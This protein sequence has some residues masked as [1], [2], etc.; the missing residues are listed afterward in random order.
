MSILKGKYSFPLRANISVKKLWGFD[1]ETYGNKNTFYMGSIVGDDGIQQIFYSKDDFI[2]YLFKNYKLFT[3]GYICATNLGF[4]ITA[5]FDNH[6]KLKDIHPIIKNSNMIFCSFDTI[7][8]RHKLKF[9]DT[10]NFCP[11]SVETWGRILNF[12]K[13][14][15]PYFIGDIPKNSAEE[16]YLRDYNLNDS[17]ITYKAMQFLQ[18][19]YNELNGN[20]RI[21]APSSSMWLYRKNFQKIPYRQ[22]ERELLD[23]LYNAYYGGR[24]EVIKRGLAKNLK[25]YD[26]NSLYPSVM[27][28]SYPEPNHYKHTKSFD[29][30]TIEY[31][32]GVAHV[33]IIA[34]DLYIP[35][36]PL[37]IEKPEKKLIFPTG[38]FS[39]W[40]SFFEL[41]EALKLGYKITKRKEAIIYYKLFEPFKEY[42]LK[43]YDLRKE[44]KK[45]DNPMEILFKLNMNSLYGKFGQNIKDKEI[46]IHADNIKYTMLKEADFI[47]KVGNFYILK[48]AFNAKIPA[49]VNPIFS[50]YTTAYARDTLYKGIAKTNNDIYYYDTDSIITHKEFSVSLELGDLKKEYDIRRAI[51]VKPKMYI[52]DDKAKC[53][54]IRRLNEAGFMD[55]LNTKSAKIQRF[56]KFKESLRRGF[57]FNEKIE[58]YKKFNLEDNKRKWGVPFD[59]NALQDSEAL[60]V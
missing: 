58:F 45:Q 29:N 5:L 17:R 19:G 43:M 50:I 47:N 37:R 28:R 18:K 49:F 20:L 24:N 25:Y 56:T 34:P 22:P 42:I 30:A 33:E 59:F 27:L 35:Y 31:Y 11:F 44:Y 60:V 14:E 38:K 57:S 21:T 32:E 36:L 53:K 46:I 39:G 16:S 7:H 15:K 4:D 23:L 2:D 6:E 41:R 12:P 51:F 1:T 26:Y 10:M 48:K 9:I 55:I 54:G 13:M 3:Q 40:F 8:E 52:I